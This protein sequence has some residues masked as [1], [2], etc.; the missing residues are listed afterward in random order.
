MPFC[1]LLTFS[2]DK[3]MSDEPIEY[4]LDDESLLPQLKRFEKIILEMLDDL[5]IPGK[6]VWT[7]QGGWTMV[8]V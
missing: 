3:I 2:S 8:L 5:K 4:V 1:Q 6:P 7:D